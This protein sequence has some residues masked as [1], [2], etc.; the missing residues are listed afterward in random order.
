MNAFFRLG[1]AS[2]V[3]SLGLG[4]F[5]TP[6]EAGGPSGTATTVVNVR[7]GTPLATLSDGWGTSLCWWANQFGNGP[8]ADALADICFTT[9]TVAW[10]GNPLPGLGFTV[11]RYNVGGGGGGASIGNTVENVSPN[12]P[13][14]KNIRGYW[15][16]WFSGDPTSNSWNW[17][18]DSNQRN[19]MWHARDRGV[20]AI[21]F[22][23][24]SP[25]WWMCDNHSTAG[26]DSGGENLQAWNHDQHAFYMASVVAYANKNWGVHVDSVEAFNEP[27]GYWWK[28]PSNQEG[29]SITPKT[30]DS[31]AG[32]LRQQ[33]NKL[34]Q[35]GVGVSASDENEV[36]TALSTWNQ[37]SPATKAGVAKINTHG[38]GQ[39]SDNGGNRAP[40]QAAAASSG[41]KLWM[42]EYGD[43]D[44]SG[45]TMAG[46][47]VQ[48]LNI[49]RPSA[50]VYWQALDGYGWGL[51]NCDL[52]G[53]TIG[54][55][56]RKYFALAQFSRHIRPGDQ[57]VSNS[58]VD[59]GAPTT[60]VSRA[61]DGKSLA[62]ITVNKGPAQFFQYNLGS[63]LTPTSVSAWATT[64]TPGGTTPD[65][66][67]APVRAAS[68]KPA[69]A[70]TA[71]LQA[72]SVTTIEVIGN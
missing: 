46:C 15:L 67:Y 44:S 10:Q 39:P 45:S 36:R 2:L 40:L 34:G 17:F 31:V 47:V 7:Q 61:A 72:N 27:S 37:F 71:Y 48:D 19:M 41:K 24:N 5:A 33:L 4:V 55:P 62:I 18:V 70:V 59:G 69:G 64:F 20:G 8:E 53:N 57:V 30:Q 1:F 42:S 50:W 13:L 49:L 12:M 65:L 25:M 21:E 58:T 3:C 29:C 11:I 43:G 51:L 60:V 23:S 54:G 68:L 56:S 35:G 6:A 52:V 66:L 14:A 28:Y 32:S 38:Y 16:N 63:G 26:S 22:F 9:K